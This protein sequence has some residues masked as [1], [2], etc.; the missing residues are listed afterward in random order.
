MTGPGGAYNQLPYLSQ[1]FPH[2]HPTRLAALAA[3]Y[4][5]PAPDASR[6]SVLELGCASGGNII[7]LALRFPRSRFRG[8][9]LTERH[10][11]DGQARVHA[12]GLENIRIEQGDIAVLDLDGERFDYIIC[13]GVYSWVPPHV[14]ETI[15][16]IC[17]ENLSD[18]GV[19]YVSYNVYPGWHL[20]GVIRDMMLYHAGHS[21]DPKERVA[22][23]RSVL[24]QIAKFSRA[25]SPYGELLRTEVKMLA[26]PGRFLH[27]RRVPGAGERTLLFPRLRLRG[28]GTGADYLCEADIGDCIPEQINPEVGATLRMMSGNDLIPLEQYMDFFKGRTFRRTLLVKTAQAAKIKRALTP[29]RMKDLHVSGRMKCSD[30]GNGMWTFSVP[31][32]GAMYSGHDGVRQA[33]QLLS[34]AFPA[35]RTMAQLTREVRGANAAGPILDAV[36]KAMLLGLVDMSTVPLRAPSAPGARPRAWRLSRLD[37]AQGCPWTAGPSGIVVHLDP[38]CAELLPLLDGTRDRHA[39]QEVVLTAAQEGRIRIQLKDPKAEP[40][41][42]RSALEKAAG[43]W[44]TQALQKMIDAA[45][46]E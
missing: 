42:S 16:R 4:G 27:P 29:E 11:R 25:G 7:P 45:I 8:V 46:L 28:R 14:R 32:R 37:A 18:S 31:G 1:P 2:S 15:L 21:G 34:E 20:R 6:C 33:L 30:Q 10:V 44:V 13:H 40:E 19:A 43:V 41:V 9:D 39:L 38:V 12:L 24:D 17:G 3:M 23:A 22:K 26:R 36:Y 5:L 35:T